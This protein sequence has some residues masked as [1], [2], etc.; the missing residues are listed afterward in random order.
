MNDLRK[1][2]CQIAYNDQKQT[3]CD[4]KTYQQVLAGI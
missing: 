1:H 2:T 4:V 3:P